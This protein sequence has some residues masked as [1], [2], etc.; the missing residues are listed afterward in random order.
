MPRPSG[1]R[2]VR[3]RVAA[4]KDTVLL[5]EA[6]SA[7]R[8]QLSIAL[9]A[10]GLTVTAVSSIAEIERWPAGDVVVTDGDRFTPWWARVGASHV[11]V[12]A[13]SEQQG[14]AAC[15]R[16]A[17]AWVPRTCSPDLLVGTVRGLV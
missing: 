6:D 1:P 9:A 4:R 14:V 8:A 17:T 5:I 15:E 11:I 7:R 10:S 16:G 12:L 3:R 2:I 13:D